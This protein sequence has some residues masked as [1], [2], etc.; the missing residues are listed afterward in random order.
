M[1]KVEIDGDTADRIVVCSLKDSIEYLKKEIKT[2]KRK[3]KL[4]DWEMLQLADNVI[5]LDAMEK[6]FDYYGGNLK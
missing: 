1:D 4:D 3:K 5:E 6:V 2:L